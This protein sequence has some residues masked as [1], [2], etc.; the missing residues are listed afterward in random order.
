MK[1]VN[2]RYVGQLKTA[3]FGKVT[4][5]EN[6]TIATA[7]VASVN[8]RTPLQMARRITWSNIIATYR[9]MKDGLRDGWENIP[10]GQSLYN[11]FIAV[12]ARSEPYAL[13]QSDFKSGACI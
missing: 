8:R 4:I 1:K 6:G 2:G 5:R 7:E 3:M 13:T 12:N 11:Q 9:V 10:E